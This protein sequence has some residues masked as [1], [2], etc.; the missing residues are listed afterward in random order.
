MTQT[1]LINYTEYRSQVLHVLDVLKSR[2]NGAACGQVLMKHTLYWSVWAETHL[3]HEGCCCPGTWIIQQWTYRYIQPRDV[4][5]HASVS[6]FSSFSCCL[7]ST[8]LFREKKKS[9]SVW[10]IWMESAARSREINYQAPVVVFI[11]SVRSY[12]STCGCGNAFTVILSLH[13]SAHVG[14]CVC[15]FH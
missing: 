1:V 5:M 3:R 2:W 13:L 10:E 4:W 9:A 6:S 12:N 8:A 14:V 11:S 7:N 15:A